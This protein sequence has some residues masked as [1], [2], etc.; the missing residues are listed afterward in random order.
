[1][2][3]SDSEAERTSSLLALDDEESEMER[4]TEVLQQHRKQSLDEIQTAI[5]RAVTGFGAAQPQGDDQTVILIR[6]SA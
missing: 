3:C 2:L 6:R 4:L 1:M 5:D